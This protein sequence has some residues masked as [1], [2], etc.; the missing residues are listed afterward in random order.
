MENVLLPQLMPCPVAL[1]WLAVVLCVDSHSLSGAAL[2]FGLVSTRANQARKYGYTVVTSRA[3]TRRRLFLFPHTL[4]SEQL[5]GPSTF[6]SS[7]STH[8]ASH[9]QQ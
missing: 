9:F 2:S 3:H 1:C 7:E 8:H 4:K 5:R 6:P